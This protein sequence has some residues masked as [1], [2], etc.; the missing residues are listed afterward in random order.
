MGCV[1]NNRLKD[2]ANRTGQRSN[3]TVSM[4]EPGSLQQESLRNCTFKCRMI[5]PLPA[6]QRQA[7]RARGVPAEQGAHFAA[8]A[9]RPAGARLHQCTKAAHQ[10]LQF[11]SAFPKQCHEPHR[12]GNATRLTM[13]VHKVLCLPQKRINTLFKM[14]GRFRE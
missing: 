11:C 6:L 13:E 8:K 4:G 5:W 2:F 12:G 9:Y 3:V 14:E 1:A 7:G 10:R